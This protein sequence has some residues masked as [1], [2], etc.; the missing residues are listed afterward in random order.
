MENGIEFA[1]HIHHN[2]L[3][4]PL[5]SPYRDRV[6]YIQTCKPL[7]EREIRLR[8]FKKVRGAL[9]PKYVEAARAHDKAEKDSVKAWL[10]HEKSR[11]YD[12]CDKAWLTYSKAEQAY[13]K[14][15]RLY[16][17]AEKSCQ[18][19]I[20]KLHAQECRN[21]PWNGETIF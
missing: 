2:T 5:I 9:P 21:C 10:A 3:V 19:E 11:Y 13:Y 14:T 12:S 17:E 16:K 4:E 18:D 15:M 6:T 1:W 8:L 20:L 7:A